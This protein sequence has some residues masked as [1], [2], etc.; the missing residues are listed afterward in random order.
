[1]SA[2]KGLD[3]CGSGNAKG[4]VPDTTLDHELLHAVNMQCIQEK[5]SALG[6]YIAGNGHVA[7]VHP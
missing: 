6:N 3:L 5:L 2:K 1:M 4:L 7:L